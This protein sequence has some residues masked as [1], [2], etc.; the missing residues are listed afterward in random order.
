MKILFT[1]IKFRNLYRVF[2]SF[3][4]EIS[5]AATV[6]LINSSNVPVVIK[7]HIDNK[8]WIILNFWKCH[9]FDVRFFYSQLYQQLALIILFFHSWKTTCSKI[10]HWPT[11]NNFRWKWH[12]RGWNRGKY[13]I[14]IVH[15][16]NFYF[17]HLLYIFYQ[18]PSQWLFEEF[19]S[20]WI[21]NNSLS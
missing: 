20:L 12:R 8:E 16:I 2:E 14:S 19:Y 11:I 7:C 5:T 21:L 1:L 3:L 10:G 15:L 4:S 13:L 17:Q 18:Y 6:R 9:N